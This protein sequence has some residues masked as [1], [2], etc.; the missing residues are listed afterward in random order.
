[1]LKSI[2]VEILEVFPKFLNIKLPFLDVPVKMN[3]E[4]FLKRVEAGYFQIL[5]QSKLV[6]SIRMQG[7]F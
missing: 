4:F 6:C 3:Y 1:M 5:N 2:K 7:S